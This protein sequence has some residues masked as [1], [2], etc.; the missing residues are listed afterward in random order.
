[1]F[2]FFSKPPPEPTP[3]DRN[4]RAKCWES[5]D[6]YFSCLDAAG[7]LVPGQEDGR[8]SAQRKSYDLNCAKSWIA[9]FNKGRVFA[10]RQKQMQ[11]QLNTP[12]PF[13]SQGKRAG[14]S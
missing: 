7:V 12:Q 9:H 1:M 14:K 8:C 6:A 11:A 10:E 3:P 4:E 13:N 2:G 5:R